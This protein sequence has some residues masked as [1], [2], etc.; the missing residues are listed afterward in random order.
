MGFVP[1]ELFSLKH[2]SLLLGLIDLLFPSNYSYGIP[3]L[4]ATILTYVVILY[5][6][7]N[8]ENFPSE[9]V[10]GRIKGRLYFHS[11]SVQ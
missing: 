9:L 10:Y 2:A 7:Q 6:L 4:F 3:C 8:P 11:P 1:C 5:N